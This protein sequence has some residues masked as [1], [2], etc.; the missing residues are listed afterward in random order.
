[1][2]IEHYNEFLRCLDKG[3][4]KKAK[5]SLRNFISS[6]SDD[7]ERIEWVWTYLPVLKKNNR[8]RV[9][10]E[11]FHELIFPVLKRGYYEGNF[12]STLWLAKMI[13]NIYQAQ[14]LHKELNYVTINQLLR[15]CIEIDPNSTEAKSLLLT[16]IVRGLEYAVHELPGRLYKMNGASLAYC[17]EIEDDIEL[18]RKLDKSNRY[19]DFFADL[20][21]K[22]NNYKE[23]LRSNINGSK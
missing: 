14:D 16:E 21:I 9:R 11:L 12:K 23:R 19:T 7:N 20:T 18:A 10:Y 8:S 17:K 4:K 22:L 13:Q 3:L 5:E 1:M 2:I 6:F 15:K